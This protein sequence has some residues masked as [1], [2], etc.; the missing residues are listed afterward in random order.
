KAILDDMGPEVIKNEIAN[1]SVAVFKLL[2]IV[3]YLNGRE[4]QYLRE[5]DAA[6]KKVNDLDHKLFEM[7]VSFDDYKNKYAL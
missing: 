5:K 4:C 3:N 2:D 7:K 1:S 6:Q